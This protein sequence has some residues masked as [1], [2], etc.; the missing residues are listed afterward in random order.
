M[1]TKPGLIMGMMQCDEAQAERTT[2]K[3]TTTVTP[4]RPESTASL[5]YSS[6]PGSP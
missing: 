1:N 3:T 5:Q 6:K 4:S 2:T